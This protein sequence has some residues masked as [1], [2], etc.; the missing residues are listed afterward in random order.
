MSGI[1]II[2][3]DK[4]LIEM[5]EQ[6]Y[7]SELILQELLQ[8]YPQLLAGKQIDSI[9]PRRWLLI[10]REAGIPDDE[11]TGDRWAIDHLF[12]DQDAVP[13]IVEVKRST[14]TRIRREVVG[15]MLDYASNAVVYWP[16][17][18]IKSMYEKTCEE[19]EID[20]IRCLS[21]FLE[22]NDDPDLFWSQM[23]TNLQAGK[24]RMLFVA[25]EIPS[26][27]QRIVEFLNEQMD[28]AE[29]LAIEI[30]QFMGDELKT[31]VPRVIG[32]TS[33]AKKRKGVEG[34][35]KQWDENSFFKR[36]NEDQ[37][38]I[39]RK[40]FE[41]SKTNMSRIWWGKGK[42]DGSFIPVLDYGGKDY[43][44]FAVRTGFKNNPHV[45][46]QFEPLSSRPPFDDDNLRI[47]FLNRLNEIPEVDLSKDSISRY[48]SIPFNSLNKESS[49]HMLIKAFEWFLKKMREQN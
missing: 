19:K 14:D 18:K 45:Q 46:I 40:L 22:T 35:T 31:L 17:E 24:I 10:C 37:A 28:P 4:E 12:I 5:T 38:K 41:W 32:L 2:K 47:E 42:I 11:G 1:F 39:A 3:G 27:L 34:E 29:V 16:L 13:T 23:K 26:E 6:Q 48:P 15:Q 33:E 49:L 8:D 44:A 21:E 25:D 7:E 30:K 9:N 20:P 43:F 36:L